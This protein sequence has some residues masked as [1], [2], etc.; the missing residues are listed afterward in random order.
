MG[1][2]GYYFEV[3]PWWEEYG[4][5]AKALYAEHVGKPE[6]RCDYETYKKELFRLRRELVI[7]RVEEMVEKAKIGIRFA[8]DAQPGRRPRP[9]FVVGERDPE[10]ERRDAAGAGGRG[11]G[12]VIAVI[13]AA[14]AAS[15]L[16]TL[17]IRRR[18]R[19]RRV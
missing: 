5:R 7:P 17:L 15:F 8:T 1:G 6:W 12:W 14:A 3:G 2:L 11:W 16:A 19:R 18:L 9:R 10:Q 13:V 4:R